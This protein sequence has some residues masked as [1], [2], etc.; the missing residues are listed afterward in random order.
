MKVDEFLKNNK[1]STNYL[2]GLL[3]RVLFTTSII[4]VVLILCNSNSK[5]KSLV[6]KYI[7]DENYNFSKINNIY[8]KYISKFNESKEKVTSVNNEKLLNYKSSMKY[9]NGVLLTVEEENVKMLESG[10]IVYIG[11]KNDIENVIVVQ[12]SNG[13]DVMYGY[14]ENINVKVYDYVEKG[15]I[16]G[17]ASNKLYLEFSKD[18]E[19]IDYSPYIK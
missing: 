6:K 16:L 18:G 1:K 10:L 2:K 15:T 7:V 3:K 4:L 12:Q 19:V 17:V 13:I 9:K 5:I 14:V 11:T 8:N